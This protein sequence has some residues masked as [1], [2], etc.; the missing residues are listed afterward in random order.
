M[1]ETIVKI[2]GIDFTSDTT[3]NKDPYIIGVFADEHCGKTR[4][5]LTG[6]SG[7]G[8][9]V[10]EMKSYVTLDKDSAELGKKIF[11]PKDPLALISNS[12]KVSILAS[13]VE[14]QK[15]YIA[16]TKNIENATF[17]L[18]E[19]KDV[20]LVMVDKFTHYCAWKEFAINGIGENFVKIEGK[21]VQRKA[22]VVQAIIDF[23]SSL[24]QY[25]KPVLLLCSSKPDW[26][27]LDKD[28]K[29]LRNAANC[30]SFYYRKS[31]V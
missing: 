10:T 13:D 21:L 7:V 5:G 31:V 20:N 17:G 26:D 30:A 18:L 16:L 28:K 6:P 3:S 29:P 15:H 11:K 2:G 24:S 14:R 12:R 22:E 27:M 25:G 4:L 19:H 1:K 9:V 23:L 8:C